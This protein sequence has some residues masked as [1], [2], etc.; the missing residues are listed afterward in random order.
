MIALLAANALALLETTLAQNNS[1]TTALEQICA[2]HHWQGPVTATLVKNADALP[3]PD[4]DETLNSQGA[5]YRHVRLSCNGHI[6][7]E[8]HNW[9]APERLTQDMAQTLA[10]TDT[11]FGKTVA[12]LGFT[13]HPLAAKRGALPGCPTTTVLSHRALL[14]LPDGRPLALVL[15]C[16]TPAS[17]GQ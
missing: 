13:R 7:S 2:A 4:T 10:T 16:Y 9:Y 12:A 8:A 15:E 14:S 17:L 3:A 6:L 5:G 11:P 1:A